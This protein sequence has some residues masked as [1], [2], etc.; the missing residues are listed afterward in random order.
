[1]EQTLAER[2]AVLERAHRRLRRVVIVL[3]AMLLAAVLLGA[4]GGTDGV[5]KGRTLQLVDAEGRVRILANA[6]SGLSFLDANGKARAILGLDGND[7]PGLVLYGDGSRAILNLTSDG[8]ALAFTGSGGA[9]RAI[10]A[11]VGGE[12]GLVFY[13]DEQRE[14][15][16]L[17]V[18][19]SGAHA[20][21]L[22]PDGRTLWSAP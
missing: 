21:L 22:G 15:A 9:L 12:P 16:R 8:P 17:A 18:R 7:L 2:L 14:R 5:L 11:T 10:L 19:A 13:D 1:M 6:A 3:L 20:A 4:G